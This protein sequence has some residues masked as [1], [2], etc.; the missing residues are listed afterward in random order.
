MT[1]RKRRNGRTP[2]SAAGGLLASKAEPSLEPE[3]K[4]MK[5]KVCLV[6]EQG[7]G[8]TS[9][10]HR[11]VRGTFDEAYLRTLGASVSKKTVD[12]PRDAGGSVQV[13]MV[14]LDIMGKRTFLQLFED[15]YLSGAAGVVAVFDLTHGRTLR[16]LAPWLQSVRS[17]VGPI[18]TIVLGNKADLTEQTDVSEEDV[19]SALGPFGLR[20]QRTSAKTG[21]N[22]EAAFLDLARDLVGDFPGGKDRPG[23]SDPLEGAGPLRRPEPLTPESRT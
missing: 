19:T 3:P 15:A 16:G 11:F 1:M 2:S 4:V 14:I 7:V 9:L 8:K 18:P 5:R 21:E 13:E 20:V 23:P 10:I 6:G 12:V 17:A 22:V